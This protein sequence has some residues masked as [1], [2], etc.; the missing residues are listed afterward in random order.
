MEEIVA[1]GRTWH[2]LC[3]R[4]AATAPEDPEEKEV[5]CGKKLSLTDYSERKHPDGESPSIPYCKTCYDKNFAP[6]GYGTNIS[7]ERK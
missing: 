2:K 4:C 3:F 7:Q 6:K 5:R 1:L